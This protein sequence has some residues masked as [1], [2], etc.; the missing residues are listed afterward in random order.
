MH[1]IPDHWTYQGVEKLLVCWGLW[2]SV[3]LHLLGIWMHS[4]RQEEYAKEDYYQHANSH[5]LW[6]SCQAC[7]FQIRK[8]FRVFL[9]HSFSDGVSPQHVVSHGNGLIAVASGPRGPKFLVVASLGL[10]NPWLIDGA[11]ISFWFSG[12]CLMVPDGAWWCLMVLFT[13]SH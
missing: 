8:H 3:G 2:F 1:I 5:F 12:W 10:R 4:I 13:S 7:S 11:P 9:Q 6:I